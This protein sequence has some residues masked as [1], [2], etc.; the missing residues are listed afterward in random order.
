M[1]AAR[2]TGHVTVTVRLPSDQPWRDPLLDLLRL[3]VVGDHRPHLP[4]VAAHGEVMIGGGTKEEA[5]LFRLGASTLLDYIS[6]E[7]VTR[8]DVWLPCDLKG[9]PQPEV[10][11]ANGPRLSAALRDLSEALDSETDPDDPTYFAT[12]NETGAENFFDE[13]GNALDVWVSFEVPYRY[14]VFTRTPGFRVVSDA[15]REGCGPSGPD[16][17]TAHRCALRLARPRSGLTNGPVR[18]D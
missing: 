6:V 9:R 11:V 14:E 8:T 1:S 13:N 5:D 12:P 17:R 7:L 4:P 3:L 2:D 10:Y 16:L 18:A 15:G